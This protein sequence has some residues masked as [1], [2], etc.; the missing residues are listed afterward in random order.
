MCD[1]IPVKIVI[2]RSVLVAI[3][4]IFPSENNS[5]IASAKGNAGALA[6][7]TVIFELQQLESA[8][9]VEHDSSSISFLLVPL[10]L[11]VVWLFI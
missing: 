6:V 2:R 5:F 3:P 8:V 10:T 4:V 9:L 1:I 7:E 11:V